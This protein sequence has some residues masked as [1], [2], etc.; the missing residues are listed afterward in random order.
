VEQRL[1]D[2]ADRV[3]DERALAKIRCESSRLPEAGLDVLQLALD[4]AV[5]LHGVVSGLFLNR[6]DDCR[7]AVETGVAALRQRAAESHI[8]HLAERERDVPLA[9]G[10]NDGLL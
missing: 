6:Q 4:S 2:I 10:R 3:F 9:V 1:L 8:S 7:F 5:Q